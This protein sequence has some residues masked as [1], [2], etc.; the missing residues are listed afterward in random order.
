[1]KPLHVVVQDI[2]RLILILALRVTASGDA[3]SF[4]TI[5]SNLRD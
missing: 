4:P 2:T 5:L 3:K 1:M